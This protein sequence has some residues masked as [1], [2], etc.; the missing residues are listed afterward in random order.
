VKFERGHSGGLRCACGC[1]RVRGVQWHHVV[2]QQEIRRVVR[3][4]TEHGPPDV[5]REM[6]LLTSRRNLMPLGPRCHAAHHNR[7]KPLRLALLP[8]SAFEFAAELLGAG[9]AYEYLKR[10][11]VGE[12][13]RLDALLEDHER[14]SAA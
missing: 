8:D 1:G 10:R 5:A 6:A 3:E 12:D 2:Y 13:P 11:Y 4:Q 14:S 9:R 7:S